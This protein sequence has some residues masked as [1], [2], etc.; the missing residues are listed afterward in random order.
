[1]NLLNLLSECGLLSCDY[2]LHYYVCS[3]ELFC[4]VVNYY[5]NLQLLC[6][7]HLSIVFMYSC[8]VS[9]MIGHHMGR[10]VSV[11]TFRR[12]FVFD[13]YPFELVRF[14]YLLS[15]YLFSCLTIPFSI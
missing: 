15:P 14:R 4:E 11:L 5:H 9:W 7:Y 1:M 3:C 10:C 6:Y 2:I 8:Q 13:I 12:P